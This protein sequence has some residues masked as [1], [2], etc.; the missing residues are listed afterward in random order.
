MRQMWFIQFQPL[1]L[2]GLPITDEMLDQFEGCDLQTPL[3]E[4]ELYDLS[5]YQDFNTRLE[6]WIP[7]LV[8]PETGAQIHFKKTFFVPKDSIDEFG[9]P[10]VNNLPDLYNFLW[11]NCNYLFDP[12]QNYWW[13]VSCEEVMTIC[14]DLWRFA[15]FKE[16]SDI[17][18]AKQEAEYQKALI[19][20]QAQEEKNA[21]EE[22]ESTESLFRSAF[23]QKQGKKVKKGPPP[24]PSGFAKVPDRLLKEKAKPKVVAKARDKVIEVDDDAEEITEVDETRAPASLIFIGH[25]DAGKSTICGNLMYLTGMVDERTIKQYQKE[26]QDKKMDSWWLAYVMDTNEEE[27]EKGKTVEVGKATLQTNRIRYT[28]FDAPGHKNYVPNMIA[29]AS[30]ADFAALVIS[31]RKGEFEAGFERDGQTREHAQLAKSLGVQKIVV[32]VNKMDDCQWSI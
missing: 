26:A 7:F 20:W 13:T 6:Q 8:D 31:A 2:Q 3:S 11:T 32:V 12:E 10:I 24:K 9:Y 27:K 16:R 25:V 17:E 14:S 19:E 15:D 22:E 30:C 18:Y 21:K 23:N 29:G 1:I 5:I 4:S 28:I